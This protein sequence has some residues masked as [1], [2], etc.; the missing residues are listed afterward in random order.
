M[1]CDVPRIAKGPVNLACKHL[2]V[3]EWRSMFNVNACDSLYKNKNRFMSDL[4]C[5]CTVILPLLTKATGAEQM[6]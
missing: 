4:F 2:N 3:T 1:S 6:R 5:S